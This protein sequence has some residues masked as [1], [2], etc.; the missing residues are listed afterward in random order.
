MAMKCGEIWWAAV[1]EAIGNVALVDVAV[2]RL[3]ARSMR[4]IDGGLRLALSLE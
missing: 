1:A 2:R 4:S 3:P